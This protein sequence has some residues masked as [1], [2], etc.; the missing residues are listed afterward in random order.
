MTT[1]LAEAEDKVEVEK[2]QYKQTKMSS[3]L[4]MGT[5]LMGALLGRRSTRN[6]ASSMRSMNRSSKEKND[7]ER[8]EDNLE[9]LQVKF[10]DLEHEFNDAVAEL[11]DK[12]SLDNL[13]YNDLKLSPRKSDIS[14][15]DFGLCWLP[16]RVD[17]SGIATPIY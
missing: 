13:E 3:Y 2:E 12:L 9:E 17:S 4:S 1:E 16:W 6:A 11:E 10:E 5:T 14:V 15:E 7:I 8:A